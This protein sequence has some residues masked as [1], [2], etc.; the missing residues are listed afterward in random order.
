MNKH[1]PKVA[2][3]IPAFNE[4]LSLR[5]LLNELVSSFSNQIEIVV[6]DDGSLDSTFDIALKY[7]DFVLRHM[8]NLGKG[9]A[10]RT[11]CRFAFSKLKADYVIMMDAD[12]QHAV[13]DLFKFIEKINGGNNLIFGV[14]SLKKMPKAV[15]FANK[16][17]SLILK[18]VYGVYIPDILSGYKALSREMYD[19]FNWQAVGYEIEIELAKKVA[20]KRMS[21][22]TLPIKT[23][24]PNY[25]KGVSFI[26][27]VRVW[28][29]LFGI[30]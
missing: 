15:A 22:I 4:Q 30:K 10:L 3:V 13:D 20:K 24:Y 19:H 14:R 29:N 16:V 28:I 18:V 25:V 9:A 2:I 8:V 6:V 7:T 26:D 11:G 21:F 1:Q 17:T 5:D 12:R 27:A 23:I